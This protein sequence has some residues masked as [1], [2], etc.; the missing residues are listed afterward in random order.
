MARAGSRTRSAKTFVVG[1]RIVFD[2]PACTARA[3]A[4]FRRGTSLARF[5]AGRVTANAIDAI[6]RCA[7]RSYGTRGPI[8]LRCLRL[9]TR[10][11]TIAFTRIAFVVGIARIGNCAASAIHAATFFR[12]AARMTRL[13]ADVATTNAVGAIPGKT[14]RLGH[15]WQTIV[16]L[17][18]SIAAALPAITAFAIGIGCRSNVATRAIGAAAFFRRGTSL[19]ASRTCRLATI[20]I[21]AIARC[22]LRT[23][24]ARCPIGERR[25]RLVARARAIAFTRST[26]VIGIATGKNRST[27]AVVTSALARFRARVTPARAD[28]SATETIDAKIGQALRFVGAR[29]AIVLFANAR[30]ITGA[31][32]AFFVRVF[33]VGNGPACPVRAL[34][35][36]GCSAR[37][38]GAQTPAVATHAIGTITRSALRRRRA[39]RAIGKRRL[40]TGGTSA[41]AIA[42]AIGAFVIR[43]RRGFDRATNAVLA[44]AFFRRT[45][46]LAAAHA[47]V[48]ATK[49]VYAKVRQT[50]RRRGARNTVVI[51]ALVFPV[52]RTQG[53]IV[54]G[55]RVV[56]DRA[57]NPIG[58]TAFFRRAA[59]H[60]FVVAPLVATKSIDTISRRALR[61]RCT[62][63]RWRW[64]HERRQWLAPRTPRTPLG[65]RAATGH[66]QKNR[67][68]QSKPYFPNGSPTSRCCFPFH[69]YTPYSAK[70]T[71]FP[72]KCSH[73]PRHV[74]P[75]RLNSFKKTFK[76][77]T[78]S[79]F[80]VAYVA[81]APFPTPQVPERLTIEY[82]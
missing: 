19:A 52:T 34:V 46:R 51:L 32:P 77:K 8:A 29:H 81:N 39:R 43:V 69:V 75:E 24:Y 72:C 20:S 47:N 40:R 44:A 63:C 17:A 59:G 35:F 53:T 42:I 9:I 38:T 66:D 33:V 61:T 55:I 67:Q 48:V 27:C 26:L 4:F 30:A 64:L 58:T 11:R 37:L 16:E 18:R 70:C 56:F 2:G 10:A 50:L 3:L 78:R 28:V 6:A 57:A 25:L 62:G 22:T 54:V 45:T 82:R 80:G 1:V 13:V 76:R 31:A 68:R 36:L 41:R 71:K 65:L 7:L 60:A 12:C 15:A 74:S 5:G 14:L 73:L 21:N 49:P 79:R 23:R